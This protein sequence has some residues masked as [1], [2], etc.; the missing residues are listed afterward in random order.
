MKRPNASVTSVI[1]AG[2]EC[3]PCLILPTPSRHVLRHCFW[4]RR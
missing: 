3:L 4:F 2:L 1:E